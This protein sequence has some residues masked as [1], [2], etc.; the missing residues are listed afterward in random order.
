MSFFIVEESRFWLNFVLLGAGITLVY[1]CLRIIRRVF[2]H[3][4]IWISLEDL[5]YWIFVSFSI[6]YLLYYENNGAFRWFAIFGAALGMVLYKKSLSEWLVARLSGLLLWIRH[7]T[8]RAWRF[9]TK[10]FC[11]AGSAAAR[12]TADTARRVKRALR[13]LK[14]RLTAWLK[15][16]K[17]VLWKGRR[18]KQRGRV[19]GKEKNCV[20]T[21]EKRK[22]SRYADGHHH[23]ADAPDRR[24]GQRR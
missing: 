12:R 5:L 13:F 20:S 4:I 16:A 21:E 22:P 15:M 3:G 14:K 11:R 9:L 1:D 17:M 23:R 24:Y 7:L 10:P 18:G 2:P 8:G 19:N 6:F